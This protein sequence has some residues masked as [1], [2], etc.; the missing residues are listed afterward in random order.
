MSKGMERKETKG[1]EKVSVK[2]KRA[3]KMQKAK[4]KKG[5]CAY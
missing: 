3:K 5:D 1:K 4:D 2:E